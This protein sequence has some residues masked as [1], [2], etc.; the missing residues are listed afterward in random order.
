M[1]ETV[2]FF[3]EHFRIAERIGLMPLMRFAKVAKSGVDTNELEGLAV[4][5]DLLEQ[6]LAAE[7]W[8]RFQAAADKNRA[9]GD[10][11]MKIVSDV[12]EILSE[13]P[14]QRPSAS[15]DGPQTTTAKSTDGSSDAEAMELL[16]GRPDLQV[17][18]LRRREFLTS[19]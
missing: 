3:G 7:E 16:A 19:A 9:D 18:L 2:E 17:A 10:E 5:Y 11:L 8:E 15:S 12:F 4:M 1:T 14:T 6:C 13:R